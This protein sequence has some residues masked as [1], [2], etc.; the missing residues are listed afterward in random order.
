METISAV[1]GLQRQRVAFALLALAKYQNAINQKNNNWVSFPLKIVFSLANV[2]MS[3]NDQCLLMND[4]MRLGLLQFNQR[5]DNLNVKVLYSCAG[6][7]TI[8]EIRDM[9]NLG[10]QYMRHCVGLFLECETCSAVVPR[11]APRQKYC[12]ECSQVERARKTLEYYRKK[13]E[14]SAL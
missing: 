8:I 5:V 13:M 2:K 1:S 12:A 6:G 3:M 9:R 10:Y 11:K 4:L 14:N 7:N